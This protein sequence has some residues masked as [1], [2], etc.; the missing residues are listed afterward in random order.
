MPMPEDTQDIRALERAVLY[1][2]DL[3]RKGGAAGSGTDANGVLLQHVRPFIRNLMQGQ[4]RVFCESLMGEDPEVIQR[5]L[6]R[7][8]RSRVS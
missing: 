2:I 7:Y 4:E 1:A 5:V 6:A 3:A 8:L